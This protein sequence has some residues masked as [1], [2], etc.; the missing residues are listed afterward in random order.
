MNALF[1]IL[2]VISWVV[3]YPVAMAVGSNTDH[4]VVFQIIQSQMVFDNS[5]VESATISTP[6]NMAD[7]Y[8]VNLK[9]KA[10][11]A[12]KLND[13]AQK[14]MGKQANII[15]NR[16]M[17]SSATIQGQLGAEFL[18]TGL[19]KQEAHQFIKSLGLKR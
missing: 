11:A 13:L 9:L 2:I 12:N 17:V 1:R 10:T 15:L 14:N 3:F 6:K 18:V 5:T 8:G 16:K 4:L 7:T 19:T